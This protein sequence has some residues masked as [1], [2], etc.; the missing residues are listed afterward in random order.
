[1]GG[2]ELALYLPETYVEDGRQLAEKILFRIKQESNP[3]VTVSIGISY[4]GESSDSSNLNQLFQRADQSL[5]EAKETGKNKF[6]TN[7]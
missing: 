6:V 5:Y 4:W 2:E 3:S 7:E 1:M